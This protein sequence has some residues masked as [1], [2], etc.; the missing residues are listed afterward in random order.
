MRN[1][2]LI[3]VILLTCICTGLLWMCIPKPWR[4]SSIVPPDVSVLQS[5][6]LLLLEND[7]FRGYIVRLYNKKTKY[8]HIGIVEIE[9]DALFLLHA[10]PQL[11]CIRE[12]LESLFCRNAYRSLLV[13]RHCKMEDI[14][15]V[16]DFCKSAIERQTSFNHS[17]RYQSGTGYYCSEF[18]VEA[19]AAANLVLL[20][21]LKKGI[22]ILPEDFCYASDLKIVFPSDSF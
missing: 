2:R 10:D 15:E 9:N 19:Y 13:L 7:S 16:I 20:N 11:G 6:D 22:L 14:H 12:N 8:S 4:T 5:G 21:D 3:L 17:F 1:K 18:V